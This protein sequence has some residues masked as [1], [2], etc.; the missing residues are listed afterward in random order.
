MSDSDHCDDDPTSLAVDEEL[1]ELRKSTMK[2]VDILKHCAGQAHISKSRDF[3]LPFS[4]L[5]IGRNFGSFMVFGCC[6]N[7]FVY[8]T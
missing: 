5:H 7:S 6:K 4:H 3:Y 8:D 1:E 2:E